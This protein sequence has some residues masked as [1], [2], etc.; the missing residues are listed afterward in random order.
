MCFIIMANDKVA[1][2]FKV[3]NLTRAAGLLVRWCMVSGYD[4]YSVESVDAVYVAPISFIAVSLGS[5]WR[6]QALSLQ[7]K[8]FG[9]GCLDLVQFDL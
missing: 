2:H 7:V 6:Q 5:G 4:N 8:P 3:F 9:A 1:I